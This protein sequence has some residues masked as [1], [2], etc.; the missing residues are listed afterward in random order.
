MFNYL[1]KLTI[2]IYFFIISLIASPAWASSEQEREYLLQI[3]NQLNAIKPLILAAEKEQPDN[4]RFRFHYIAYQGQDGKK[5]NGL[6]EDLNEIER[7]IAARLNNTTSE[8]HLF[9]PIQGDYTDG[10][11][12]HG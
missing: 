6:L 11:K 1:F 5:H 8:A 3:I 10:E 7:G 12:A 2:V 9:P 4:N